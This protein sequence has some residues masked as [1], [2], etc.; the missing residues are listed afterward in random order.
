[1]LAGQSRAKKGEEGVHAVL[2]NITRNHRESDTAEL[3][4]VLF[5]SVE[6]SISLPKVKISL[7]KHGEK[8]VLSCPRIMSLL[9]DKF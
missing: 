7:V 3:L 5:S 9:K 1:M 2:I 4:A 8:K 6:R